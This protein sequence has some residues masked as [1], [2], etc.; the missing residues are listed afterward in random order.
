MV[1][2]VEMLHSM[3]PNNKHPFDVC[4]SGGPWD[5]SCAYCDAA[6]EIER[7]RAAGD[8]LKQALLVVS[9][10]WGQHHVA[11]EDAKYHLMVDRAIDHWKEDSRG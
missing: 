10:V 4:S 1:D 7:L 2:I 6:D 11:A 5:I 9:N 3:C 8:R